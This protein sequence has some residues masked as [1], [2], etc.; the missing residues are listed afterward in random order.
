MV[1]MHVGRVE[2]NTWAR[3][4]SYKLWIDFGAEMGI[5]TS[6]VSLVANYS[7]EGLKDQLVIC[8]VNL[9]GR[10]IAGFVSEVL[11]LGVPMRRG[12]FVL[13]QLERDAEFSDAR[14]RF[15]A[16]GGRRIRWRKSR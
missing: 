14:P 3:K 8:S 13:L 12:M 10:N 5:R 1:E 2:E 16:Y 15:Q 6:S 7:M 9:G 11:T 4:A